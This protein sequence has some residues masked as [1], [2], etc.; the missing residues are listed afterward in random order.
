MRGNPSKPNLQI[1]GKKKFKNIK[2]LLGKLLNY[3]L[4]EFIFVLQVYSFIFLMF[5]R[6]TINLT[7]SGR[8][9]KV[10]PSSKLEIKQ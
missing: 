8:E 9:H 6:K 10:I 3:I 1:L 7:C 5:L 4:S 2:K